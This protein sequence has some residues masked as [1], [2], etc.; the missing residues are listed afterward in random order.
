MR[1]PHQEVSTHRYLTNGAS[2]RLAFLT[3]RH[4]A[5]RTE[6]NRE[7]NQPSTIHQP[8]INQP[9]TNHKSAKRNCPRASILLHPSFGCDQRP[10][11][12]AT[13]TPRQ[14]S[15]RRHA[16]RKARIG[17]FSNLQRQGFTTGPRARRGEAETGHRAAQETGESRSSD[18]P[19]GHP[20]HSLPTNEHRMGLAPSAE[21]ACK[22]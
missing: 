1:Q 5:P 14:L 11:R 6:T 12:R 21:A 2:G 18:P 9:P 3:L 15:S 16:G 10:P 19:R 20:G 4:L 7:T 13:E 8:S 17:K 22:R